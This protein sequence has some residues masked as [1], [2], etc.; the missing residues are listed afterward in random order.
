MKLEEIRPGIF[1]ATTTAHELSTIVAAAR[2]YLSLMESDTSGAPPRRVRPCAL[3][4]TTS[5][6]LSQDC[7][8]RITVSVDIPDAEAKRLEETRAVIRESLRRL[9]ELAAE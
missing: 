8:S 5:T 3:S 9:A 1:T 7:A 4:S 2:M 6:P